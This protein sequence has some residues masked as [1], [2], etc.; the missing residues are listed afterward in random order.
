MAILNTSA[1]NTQALNSDSISTLS[2]TA[3]STTVEIGQNH[4]I[5]ISTTVEMGQNHLIAIPTTVEMGQNHLIAISGEVTGTGVTDDVAI[6]DVIAIKPL[7]ESAGSQETNFHITAVTPSFLGTLVTGTSLDKKLTQLDLA[8]EILGDDLFH[9]VHDPSGIPENYKTTLD[10]ITTFVSDNLPPVSGS[11]GTGENNQTYP[12]LNP[13]YIDLTLT[14]SRLEGFHGCC[15]D[16]NHVYLAPY[17]NSVGA[18]GVVARINVNDFSTI[19]LLDLS[20]TD[21][22]LK[23]FTG[24]FVDGANVYFVPDYNIGFGFGY[25]LA[26]VKTRDFST[27]DVLDL[28][29]TDALL[30][31]FTGG[32][33][34]KGYAYLFPWKGGIGTY[35]PKIDLKTFT[36]ES[37]LDLT[38]YAG[39]YA[40]GFI[41]GKY[42]YLATK[43]SSSTIAKID[44]DDFTTVEIIG[45]YSIDP[46]LNIIK[47]CCTDGIYGYFATH[48]G[49]V[50]R[51]NLTTFTF[52][53]SIN[54]AA[55]DADLIHFSGSVT[56]GR[57]VYLLPSYIRTKVAK[58]D[59]QDFTASGVDIVDFADTESGLDGFAGGC[60]TEK[61]LYLAPNTAVGWKGKLARIF[62]SKNLSSGVNS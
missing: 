45:L 62:I 16:G 50:A 54:L 5:A 42:L 4:I 27:V 26:R 7:L 6:L 18:S 53:D 39:G 44:L 32:A 56:D 48:L 28:S 34:H 20:L 13:E 40:S 51:I 30:N 41:H 25:K 60:M 21:V 9:V 37:Y 2:I 23:G 46:N 15:Y 10:A 55:I 49:H 11:V 59:M 57:Y 17:A 8:A 35:L 1:L 52:V 33:I 47:G 22:E 58:I 24:C 29:L 38:S 31:S 43:T 3:I 14:D 36:V 61:H 19:E 12:L